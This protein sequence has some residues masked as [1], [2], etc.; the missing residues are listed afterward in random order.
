MAPTTQ[1]CANWETAASEV[2][3]CGSSS[4]RSQGS[5]AARRRSTSPSQVWLK[6]G[7]TYLA[8][9]V[10]GPRLLECARV[11]TELPGTDAVAVFG[12]VDAQ[13]LQSSMTL[14]TRTAPD[15][16]VFHRV[17]EQYFAGK[18]DDGTTSRL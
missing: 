1:P 15:E 3:G 10:L 13:K 17:L 5:A 18:S 11:L 9:R 12:P 6:P 4:P 14:F 16:Q 8:H 2:T 7:P